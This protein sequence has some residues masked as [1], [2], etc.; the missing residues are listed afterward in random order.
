M[1]LTSA[2]SH[3]LLLLCISTWCSLFP[4][5]FQWYC[6]EEVIGPFSSHSN[7]SLQSSN[8]QLQKNAG[9]WWL[10][11]WEI[12]LIRQEIWMCWHVHHLPQVYFSCFVEHEMFYKSF[13]ACR[14]KSWTQYWWLWNFLPCY[15]D[16]PFLIWLHKLALL[17][18][19]VFFV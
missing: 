11:A 14:G 16:Q 8:S 9:V 19:T 7:S 18:Y 10:T 3:V 1:D 6:P 17:C 13:W 5:W 12:S 2:H 15:L 4:C